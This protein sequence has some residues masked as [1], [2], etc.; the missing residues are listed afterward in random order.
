MN[1]IIYTTPI[2]VFCKMAKQ[3]FRDNNVEFTEIDVAEDEVAREK[4]FESSGQMGVPVID[5]DGKIVVG[6]NRP[7]LAELL[8]LHA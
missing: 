1:V 2:C 3:F 4:M 6:F 5:I 7:K 8:N